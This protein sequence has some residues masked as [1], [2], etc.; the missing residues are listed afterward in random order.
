MRSSRELGVGVC[1]DRGSM[2]SSARA[3]RP[4]VHLI[5]V[6]VRY[7]PFSYAQF[8][9]ICLFDREIAAPTRWSQPCTAACKI[10]CNNDPLKGFFA[11]NNDPFRP[12]CE[13]SS[14]GPGRLGR[15][16]GDVWRGQGRRDT[17][18]L[19]RTGSLDQGDREG[20]FGV[21]GDGSQGDP[22]PPNRVQIRSGHSAFAEAWRLGRC[23]D[24]DSRGGIQAGEAGA[25]FDAAVVR[26][27]S[28]ARI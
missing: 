1:G 21:A 6:G 15:T 3:S 26:R 14:F 28:W 24:G 18:R 23:A 16:D 7:V 4:G 27:A 17:A 19:F 2:T 25:P 20:A 8:Y 10:A 13:R 12:V 5:P 22:R 11:F 9:I